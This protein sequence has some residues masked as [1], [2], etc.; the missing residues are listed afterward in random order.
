MSKATTITEQLRAAI[1]NA[2]MTRYRIS[3][4]TKIPQSQ[5]SRFMAGESGLSLDA[6]DRLCSFLG[7][8][9]TAITKRTRT[10]R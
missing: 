2:G 6:L 9:L 8:Q 10:K 5:L 4:E 7:V 1:D 3:M